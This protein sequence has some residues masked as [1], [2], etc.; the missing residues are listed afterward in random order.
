MIAP[1]TELTKKKT[2]WNWGEKQEKAFH[3]IKETLVSA[4]LLTCQDFSKPFILR[5]DASNSGLGAVLSQ[6]GTDGEKPIAYASRGLTSAE[7]KYS[8]TELE[9]LAVSRNSDRI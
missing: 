1:L 4:P 9:C 7:K 5:T 6:E 8:T 2:K 3:D